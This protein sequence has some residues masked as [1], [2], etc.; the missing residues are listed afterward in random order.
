MK[1]IFAGWGISTGLTFWSAMI[2]A[3]A[4]LARP[5]EQGRF[6]GILDGGRGLIEALIATVVVAAFA[7]WIE[8]TGVTAGVSLQRVIVI[9]S[10]IMLVLSP[11]LYFVMSDDEHEKPAEKEDYN[12]QQLWRDVGTIGRKPEIWLCTICILIGYQLFW[13]TYSFSA[14]IQSELGMSA[15]AAGSIT[16]AKLWMRPIGAATAGFAGDLIDRERVLAGLYI[17]SA[18]ALA[19]ITML[20]VG[21]GFAAAGGIVLAIGVLTYGIRGIFWATLE[22][23]G[24]EARIKGLA[25]G[26]ICLVGFSPDIYLPLINGYLLERYPGRTGYAIYFHGIAA[27]GLIGA[28]AALKLRSMAQAKAGL[29]VAASEQPV[30]ETG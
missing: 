15:V 4:L 10:G 17:G 6:F 18:A 19:V 12:A 22:S 2:R 23:A 3:V 8:V 9:Y 28:W 11:I 13:A 14:Y 29:S 25:I 20:P 5:H 16:A 7:Y 21:A 26:M 30:V 24:V 27:M 1:L